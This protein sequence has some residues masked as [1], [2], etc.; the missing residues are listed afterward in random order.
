M[1][2][3]DPGGGLFDLGGGLIAG[4]DTSDTLRS[5]GA[6]IGENGQSLRSEDLEAEGGNRRRV[7]IAGRDFELRLLRSGPR[8]M[9][10]LARPAARSRPRSGSR[11]KSRS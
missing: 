6:W 2:A 1:A 7:A 3:V 10:W 11:S 8:P 5:V 9:G 4:D